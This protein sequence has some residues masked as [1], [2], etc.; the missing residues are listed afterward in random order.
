M[1]KRIKSIEL[2][3]RVYDSLISRNSGR[4]VN[5]ID[6]QVS[7]YGKI[8]MIPVFEIEVDDERNPERRTCM[9]YEDTGIISL[10]EQGWIIALGRSRGSNL[11][12]EFAGDLYAQKAKYLNQVRDENLPNAI[13]EKMFNDD[14]PNIEP[15]S[16]SLIIA[17]TDGRID[18]RKERIG[19]VVYQ[20]IGEDIQ[21]L[22]E[23]DGIGGFCYPWDAVNVAVEGIEKV[24]AE[25]EG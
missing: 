15:F 24:L 19:D 6:D 16:R 8:Q 2:I 10:D 17:R 3:K 22:E 12:S 4:S 21:G 9:V 25:Y 23:T 18:A 1:E 7:R 5:L 14:L 20:T 11:S 13:L